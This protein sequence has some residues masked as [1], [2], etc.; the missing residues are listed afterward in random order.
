M[1][2]APLTLNA[3]SA[4]LPLLQG[5]PS[6]FLIYAAQYSGKA[7]QNP[8]I[9]I[10]RGSQF[11]TRLQNDL[12][13]PTIIHWHGLHVPGVMDGHPG[14]TIA[15][16]ANYDYTFPVTNRGGMYWYHTHAHLNRKETLDEDKT[17]IAI[18]ANG[19]G[20]RHRCW[21]FDIRS[22]RAEFGA[23]RQRAHNR[24][25]R[26]TLAKRNKGTRHRTTASSD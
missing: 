3:R 23:S 8:I 6:P 10:T 7:Y 20:G 15:A 26:T 1:T 21:Q 18:D 14:T 17:G 13:E 16:G 19:H 24:I 4:A 25:D 22:R 5:K 11:T 9:R 12:T 2:D